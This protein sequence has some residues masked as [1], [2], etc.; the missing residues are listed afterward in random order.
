MPITNHVKFWF[1]LE[2]L[3]K[4]AF[5]KLFGKFALIIGGGGKIVYFRARHLYAYE[6]RIMTILVAMEFDKIFIHLLFIVLLKNHE[7]ITIRPAK[8]AINQS[9]A[10][11]MRYIN[12]ISLELRLYRAI[13]SS[14]L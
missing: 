12:A 2:L 9:I 14:H 5:W 3:L 11:K 8:S 13:L 6:N 4:L 10:T 1:L 7:A